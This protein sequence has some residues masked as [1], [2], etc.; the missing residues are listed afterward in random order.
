MLLKI[1]FFL[2]L[3]NIIESLEMEKQELQTRYNKITSKINEVKDNKYS[4]TIDKLVDVKLKFEKKIKNE[5]IEVSKVL[6]T[7]VKIQN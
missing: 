5:K 6:L 1:F 2:I 4:E 7:K 3:R